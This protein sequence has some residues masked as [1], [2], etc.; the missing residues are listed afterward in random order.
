MNLD[1]LEKM[2]AK[3]LLNLKAT[4]ERLHFRKQQDK[5]TKFK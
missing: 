3:S 2:K 5:Q 4:N 1:S